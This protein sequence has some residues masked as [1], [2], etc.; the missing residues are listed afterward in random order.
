MK[1]EHQ[2]RINRFRNQISFS[3]E[4][5]ATEIYMSP[6]MALK[7]AEKL[8]NYAINCQS[9]TYGESTLAGESLKEVVDSDGKTVIL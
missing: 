6:E 1:T 5:M 4:S 8:L 2:I 9:I 7:V 3:G